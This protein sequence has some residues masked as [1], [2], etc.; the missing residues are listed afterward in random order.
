MLQKVSFTILLCVLQFQ[1]YHSRYLLID[2]DDEGS[3]VKAGCGEF[4]IVW[5]GMC[6]DP[7]CPFR[8]NPFVFGFCTP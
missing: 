2:L 5:G 6:T 7:K 3:G 4:C 1:F 8:W